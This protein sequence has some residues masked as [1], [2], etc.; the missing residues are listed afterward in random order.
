MRSRTLLM[1]AVAGTAIT[2]AAAQATPPDEGR[3]EMRTV[4][5]TPAEVD[6]GEEAFAMCVGC[7][8]QAAEGKVGLG[9]RLASE[10][11]LAAA[12]DEMLLRTILEGRTGTTMIA[13]KDALGEDKAQ[14]VVAWLRSETP[15][16]PAKLDRSALEGDADNGAEVFKAVCAGCHG[17]RGNGYTEAGP[18][19]AIG[20]RG[21][22]S[23]ASD[24]YIRY[25]LRHGKSGTKMK[26]F[27]KHNII[28]VANLSDQEIEDVIAHLREEAW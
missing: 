9:P 27:S 21:F 8:G 26:P 18:G 20:R 23:K 24:G 15:T 10:S 6:K 25:I 4:E 11:F 16:K 3:P 19:T 13:W 17:V 2:V 28:S 1:A 14:A 12:S 22:L 7:H 5:V